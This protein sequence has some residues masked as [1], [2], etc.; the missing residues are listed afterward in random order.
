MFNK[1][2]FSS[3][4]LPIIL[5]ILSAVISIFSNELHT[6]LKNMGLINL[7]STT[8]IVGA[9]VSICYGYYLRLKSKLISLKLFKD[10]EISRITTHFNT[11]LNALELKVNGEKVLPI[12]ELMKQP[13]YVAPYFENE[14][15]R[16]DELDSYNNHFKEWGLPEYRIPE[17][18][19]NN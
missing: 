16:K 9:G 14:Q 15:T 13:N 6:N 17:K 7:I 18:I 5:F 3:F 1:Q 19:F 2:N 4:T 10:K 8:L 12:S 11:Q